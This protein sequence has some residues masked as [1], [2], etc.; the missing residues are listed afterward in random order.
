MNNIAAKKT[1][2]YHL[3]V[4][5]DGCNDNI[6]TK[7]GL[8]NFLND[9]LKA[10]DMKAYGTPMIKHFAEH[11]PEAAGFSLV[12]LIETSSI[13]GHFSD[14]N[15]DAYIDIFSCKTFDKIMALQ[16][17]QSH[18]SPKSMNILFVPREAKAPANF[19]FVN[20]LS[21]FN[22]GQ[23]IGICNNCAACCHSDAYVIKEKGI[24]DW[25]TMHGYS[26]P[27]GCEH[28]AQILVKK[29]DEDSVKIIFFD[30]CI[31][32]QQMMNGKFGCKIYDNRPDKCRNFPSSLEQCKVIPQCSFNNESNKK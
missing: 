5:A 20:Y 1:W 22:H 3:L 16:I 29:L 23:M 10:I 31:N 17:I 12:Q 7:E 26:Y 15:K 11:L 28:P 32:Y 18:F 19:P 2:G 14:L 24:A 13:T 6:C 21:L 8:T 27:I 25:F 30:A 9:L 4:D